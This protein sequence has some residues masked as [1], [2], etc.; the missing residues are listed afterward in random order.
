MTVVSLPLWSRRT[1][2]RIAVGQCPTA[3][4]SEVEE[5]PVGGGL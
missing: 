4:E 2:L 3:V 1:D 5:F